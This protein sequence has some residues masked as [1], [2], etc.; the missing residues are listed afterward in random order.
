MEGM[1]G[2]DGMFNKLVSNINGTIGSPIS[3]S[4]LSQLL[5]SWKE[6]RLTNKILLATSDPTAQTR[7]KSYDAIIQL[8]EPVLPLLI[9]ELKSGN[10]YMNR[11]VLEISKL[12][13]EDIKGRKE[14]LGEEE[15]SKRLV[16]YHTFK[17]S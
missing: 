6:E 3:A 7:T 10:Y 1:E 8:G 5:D 12:T 2:M 9:K 15:I 14:I 16:K 4:R 11:A 17:L 13:L